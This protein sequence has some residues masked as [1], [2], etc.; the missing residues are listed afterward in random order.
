MKIFRYQE[1]LFSKEINNHFNHQWS[2]YVH[3][4]KA[5]NTVQI[6]LRLYTIDHFPGQ[7]IEKSTFRPVLFQSC[8][9]KHIKILSAEMVAPIGKVGG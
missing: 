5:K 2:S 8:L 3:V 4:Y 6:I 1:R 9:C 7:L